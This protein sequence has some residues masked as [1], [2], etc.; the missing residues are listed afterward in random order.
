M[1]DLE[2]QGRSNQYW[3]NRFQTTG[4]HTAAA[5]GGESLAPHTPHPDH[6]HNYSGIAWKK[7]GLHSSRQLVT[8]YQ[9]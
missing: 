7:P 2:R 3:L 6:G 4:Q 8:T 1:E 5:T 9:L